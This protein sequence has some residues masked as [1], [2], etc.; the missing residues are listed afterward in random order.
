MPS[1]RMIRRRIRSVQNTAKITNAMQLVAASKMRRAQ[2]RALAA[3][4]YAERM[5]YVLGHLADQALDAEG[6]PIHPLLEQRAGDRTLLIH[7]TPNRGLSGALPGNLN[8]RAGAFVLE[9]AGPVAI[10][11]VGKKGRDFF[12]RLRYQ[13]I[14]EFLDLGD[15]PSLADTLAIARIAM[16][17]FI[18]RRTDRVFLI[19]ADFV[20]T[21]VQRPTVLQLLPVR[22]SEAAREADTL[23]PERAPAPAAANGAHP[24]GVE[25]IYE[26]SAAAVLEQILP[27]YVEMQVYAAVLENAASEQSARMVAMK[28]ATDAAND[29]ISVLTLEMNKARQEQIT[30]EL[31]DII[32][33]VQ[34]VER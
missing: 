3:R 20:N 30:R 17:E 5:R 22:P 6:L 16:E 10:V 25:Y 29:M 27:R 4:P 26:P 2:Q 15:Y 9:Q 28:N 32:G 34:A 24:S 33:G 11:A 7:V 8:R 18:A 21:A 12:A 1:V 31:L 23:G 13:I 19:Y 14:A